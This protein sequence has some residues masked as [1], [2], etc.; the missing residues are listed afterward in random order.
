MFGDG[1]ADELERFKTDVNLTEYAAHLG[2]AVDRRASSR[3]SVALR[4]P[5]GSKVIVTRDADR[6]WVFCDVHDP[7]ASGSIVDFVQHRR[8]G[9]LGDVRKELRP[10]VGRGPLPS[11][12]PAPALFVRDLEPTGRD[13][14]AVLAAYASTT[15]CGGR[16]PYL[17]S[18]RG[19]PAAV[20]ADA[21]F[22]GRVRV[23]RRGNAVFPHFD[24]GGTVCGFE[25]KNRNFTGFAKHGEK[26]LWGSRPNP[27]DVRLVV[28]ETAVD[29]LSH[30]ALFGTGGTRFVS[31]AG[32][33]NAVQP[34]LLASAM[35]KLPDGGEVVAAVDHDAGGDALA[36][37]LE[38]LFGE[39]PHGR[40]T[41]R[42]NSP[43]EHGAD[44]NDVLAGRAA[45][46]GPE[47]PEK[48]L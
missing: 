9:T 13:V 11:D 10:W 5:D 30:A 16:H 39:L 40:R 28:A 21:V 45:A 27:D 12:R 23:D 7:R 44:W 2:F 36:G 17:E 34:A 32:Q 46:V 18:D 1:R 19:I 33:L 3:N 29:A 31:T 14:A 42:R 38:V 47:A 6:H 26:G 43:P 4:H 37:R 20:L 15:P 25:I 35:G 24:A 48:T 41:F 22:D 8:G